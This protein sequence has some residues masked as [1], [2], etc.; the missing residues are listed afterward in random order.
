M[1]PGTKYVKTPE[2]A[3]FLNLSQATVLA[4]M[5][6]RIIPENCYIMTGRTYRFDWQKVEQALLDQKK[7]LPDNGQ[8]EFDFNDDN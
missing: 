2:M 8:L 3:A 1:T 6:R 7:E 5:R 4:M